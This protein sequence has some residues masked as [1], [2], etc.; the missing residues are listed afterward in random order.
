MKPGGCDCEGGSALRGERGKKAEAD[1]AGVRA[2]EDT[3]TVVPVEGGHCVDG[4]GPN[5]LNERA[6]TP[7]WWVKPAEFGFLDGF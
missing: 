6:A 7:V 1:R 2:E 5:E 3:P 4:R